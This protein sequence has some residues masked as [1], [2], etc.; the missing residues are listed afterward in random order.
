M[1]TM[2]DLDPCELCGTP[3]EAV[4]T[5]GYDGIQQR[6]PRCGEF[7]LS[8]TGM[9]TIRNIPQAAKAKL[10][11][12]VRDQI[13]LGDIPELTDSRIRHIVA[14][15]MPSIGQRADRL[16]NYVIRKQKKLGETFTVIDPALIGV[17]YSRD[18]D[19]L[20]Y[21]VGYLRDEL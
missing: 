1:P 16:L 18:A 6:C 13:M 9:A 10:S 12:W 2:P 15:P 19:E 20:Q 7:R 5:G 3:A 8:G 14:S 17:T 21:L 11:G 4:E